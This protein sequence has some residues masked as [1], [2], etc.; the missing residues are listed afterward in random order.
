MLIM[1]Y[2]GSGAEEG[3]LKCNKWNPKEDNEGD[4]LLSSSV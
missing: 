3:T 2:N 4:I 1:F